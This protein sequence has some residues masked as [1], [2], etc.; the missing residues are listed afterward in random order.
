MPTSRKNTKSIKS[1]HSKNT[2]NTKSKKSKH[3]KN[4]K[5]SK[6]SKKSNKSFSHKNI[7]ID[8]KINILHNLEQNYL[9]NRDDIEKQKRLVINN[10]SIKP[11]SIKPK[12]I[13]NK[14]IKPISIKP[15]SINHPFSMP[16]QMYYFEEANPNIKKMSLVDYDEKYALGFRDEDLGY[17]N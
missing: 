11:K 14:S 4:S 8:E 3:T 17:R 9:R 2:K 5:K 6:H 7:N 15:K 1:K 12:S 16:K 10:K 13:K